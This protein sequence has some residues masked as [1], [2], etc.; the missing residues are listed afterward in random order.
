MIMSLN[1]GDDNDEDEAGAT[2]LTFK[3]RKSYEEYRRDLK[4]YF[5]FRQMTQSI[6]LKMF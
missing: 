2:P 5:S 4:S 6:L 3:F 1:W